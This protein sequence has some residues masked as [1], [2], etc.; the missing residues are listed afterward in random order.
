MNIIIKKAE[1][2]EHYKIIEILADEIW[3]E[4]YISI[5]SKE[6]IEY[7]LRNF[8]SENTVKEQSENG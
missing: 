6:Q 7:M 8:Q 1:K 2:T 4:C 5:I 3:N